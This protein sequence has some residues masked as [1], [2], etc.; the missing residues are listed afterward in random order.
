MLGRQLSLPQLGLFS[1]VQAS[2]SSARR[3]MK[4]LVIGLVEN[5]T[6]RHSYFIKEWGCPQHGLGAFSTVT[7]VT[8]IVVY[9]GLVVSCLVARLNEK[10]IQ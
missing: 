10:V 2:L 1:F 5:S 9:K 4:V 7:V 6:L 3:D 8:A